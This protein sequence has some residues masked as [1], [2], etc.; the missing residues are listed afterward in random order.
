PAA[1]READEHGVAQIEVLHQYLEIASKGVVVIPE[2]RLARLAKAA[3]VVSDHSI[4]IGEE[5][6][7]LAFPR[8]AIE[9]IPMDQNDRATTTV[10]LVVDLD[11]GAVLSADRDR[12]HLPLSI[13]AIPAGR[14]SNMRMDRPCG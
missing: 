14:G 6:A 1:H 12:S 11:G 13:S 2:G 5:L 7:L 8:V 10:V 3:A 4:S 9:W